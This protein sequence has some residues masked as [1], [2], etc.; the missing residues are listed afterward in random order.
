MWVAIAEKRSQAEK[1]ARA[2]NLKPTSGLYRGHFQGNDFVLW[3][4]AGH[5]LELSPPNETIPDYSWNEPRTHENIPRNVPYV[6]CP[7]LPAREGYP[8]REPQK[9][10]NLLK[11]FIDKATLVIGA[12]DPDR[13][14]EVIYRTI[15]NH[16]NFKGDLK[17]VWFSK[18]L[19]PDAIIDAF[20]KLEDADKYYGEY[21]A[22]VGRRMA[23]YSSMVLTATYTYYARRGMLGSNLGL[24]EGKASTVSVG[25]VQS[26]IV[27]FIYD[28]YLARQNFTPITH[29]RPVPLIECKGMVSFEGRYIPFINDDDYGEIFEGVKWQEKNLANMITP[30]MTDEEIEEL[31]RSN[32]PKPMYV[33]KP[34]MNDFCSRLKAASISNIDISETT[35]T[36][37]APKPLSLTKLQSLITNASAKEVLDAAQRLYD[38]GFISYPRS[39][40]SEYSTKDYDRKAITKICNNLATWE[41]YGQAAL[42]VA[43]RH[44]EGANGSMPKCYTSKSKAHE[45]LAPVAIPKEGTLKGLD[46]Q[47]FDLITTHYLQAHLPSSTY[48]VQ[49]GTITFDTEAYLASQLPLS[50]SNIERVR[51]AVGKDIS[52]A[53][54]A[55]LLFH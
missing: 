16:L 15:L 31:N 4:A 17:R 14:G 23:D 34:I 53:Q 35:A 38:A 32:R 9:R 13:E 30:D 2:L 54:L 29:Y 49:S 51:I 36:S 3:Y 28:R 8:A 43:H 25:R 37:A 27:S 1:I 10:I 52:K 7:D 44:G 22:G 39:E 21:S 46:L 12:T 55:Q 33:S 24:G 41:K 47:V 18:G 26:T 19:S 6:V 40:E 11:G 42:E 5:F 50:Q 45:A 20:N 48:N